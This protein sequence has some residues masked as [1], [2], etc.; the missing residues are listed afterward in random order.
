MP[1][2]QRVTLKTVADI[3]G[4]HT[5]TVSRALNPGEAHLVGASTV[6]LIKNVA[7]TLGY[8]PDYWA[9]SLRTQRTL[10]IGLI[11]PI[12]TDTIL[13]EMFEAAEERARLNDYYALTVSTQGR[14]EDDLIDGLIKRRVDGIILATALLEDASLD[15]LQ[16]RGVP[17]QLLNRRS[18]DHP[19]VRVDDEFGGYLAARHLLESHRRVGIITGPMTTSTASDRFDGYRRAHSELG[20]EVDSQLVVHSTFRARDGISAARKLL[21]LADPPTAIFAV[22]D[23]VAIGILSVARD[24][25]VRVPHD[26]AIV[27]YNDNETSEMLSIPLSSI[28]L[29]L[30]RIGA[31]AV[32]CLLRQIDGAKPESVVLS[33]QLHVRESSCLIR[34]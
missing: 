30:K 28:S 14:D 34:K 31:I 8:E 19:S 11:L 32:D 10:T 9:R 2:K 16:M 25:G 23:A 26:L 5:S 15:K 6:Q 27:G 4:V 20:L 24:L 3:A 17:Y 18:G 13:A 22:N 29:P 1:K 12:L 7:A 21:S 33:P